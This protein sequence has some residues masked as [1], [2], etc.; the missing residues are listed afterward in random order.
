MSFW[1]YR[2]SWREGPLEAGTIYNR[3]HNKLNYGLPSS[4]AQL[5]DHLLRVDKQDYPGQQLYPGRAY[6]LQT[7]V[8]EPRRFAP[9]PHADPVPADE[10]D[11][12][13]EERAV[14]AELYHPNF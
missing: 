5:R 3:D 11:G 2:S 14:T 12:V 10:G 1:P 13:V 8:C 9:T 4:N 6:G 7:A